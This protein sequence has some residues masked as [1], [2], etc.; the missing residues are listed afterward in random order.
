MRASRRGWPPEM[1]LRDDGTIHRSVADRRLH[2]APLASRTTLL[3]CSP[4]CDRQQ[5]NLCFRQPAQRSPLNPD[6]SGWEVLS[7][8][9]L[10]K[11][12]HTLRERISK[13]C[14]GDL[15]DSTMRFGRPNRR[16]LSL[17]LR[18]ERYGKDDRRLFMWRTK[19]R[20]LWAE[21]RRANLSLPHVP[22]GVRRA[23]RGAAVREP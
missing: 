15:A 14:W 17:V 2:G 21:T 19:I 7:E 20:I 4:D 1:E 12:S 18:G 11:F 3:G 23:T 8:S 22:E 16:V 5:R 6:K 9:N 13:A 10:G